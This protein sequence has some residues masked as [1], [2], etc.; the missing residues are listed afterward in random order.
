MNRRLNVALGAGASGSVTF[1]PEVTNGERF[2]ATATRRND[3]R[4]HNQSAIVT[5]NSNTTTSQSF[6]LNV[7]RK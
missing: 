6:G 5:F 7:R 4:S 1:T 3:A 2:N